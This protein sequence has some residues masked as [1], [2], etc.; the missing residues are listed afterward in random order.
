MENRII[1]NL[2]KRGFSLSELLIVVAIVVVLAAISV[3]AFASN[4]K[5]QQ[6]KQVEEQ[7]LAAKAAAVAAFYS[8]KDSNGK[9]VDITENGICTFLYDEANGAVYVINSYAGVDGFTGEYASTIERYGHNVPQLFDY[10]DSVILVTFDGRYYDYPSG[11]NAPYSKG[12]LEEPAI[13]LNWYS[14]GSLLK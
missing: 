10:S 8:G 3:P 1:H 11:I 9:T 2:N 6:S 14:A 5:N 4:M 12:T 13:F 7:E